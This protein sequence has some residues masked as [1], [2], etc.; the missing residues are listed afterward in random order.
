[1]KTTNRRT[2]KP[3]TKED[4]AAAILQITKVIERKLKAGE[5]KATV[6]DY[7]R[8]LELQRDF[9]QDEVSEV[10]VRWIEPTDSESSRGT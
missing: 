9:I 4:L 7:I 1:M 10:R 2:K 6:T 5:T 3:S 8:L